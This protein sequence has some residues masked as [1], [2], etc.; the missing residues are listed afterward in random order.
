[1]E[2]MV[3]LECSVHDLELLAMAIGDS[4]AANN[5]AARKLADWPEAVRERRKA[6]NDLA[7]LAETVRRAYNAAQDVTYIPA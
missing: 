6:V 5:E 3:N 2:T 1:M 7:Y 4:I